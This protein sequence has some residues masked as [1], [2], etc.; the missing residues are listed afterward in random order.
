MCDLNKRIEG[1]NFES[2]AFAPVAR[3]AFLVFR[4]LVVAAVS[5]A[6]PFAFAGV[7]AFATVV[8]GL[9]T[10]FAFAGVLAFAGVNIFLLGVIVHLAERDT[11]FGG[12]IGGMRLDGE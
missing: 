7:F 3:S 1:L 8:T 9:A 5:G 11:S 12:C 4:F 2:P 10:A 6:A